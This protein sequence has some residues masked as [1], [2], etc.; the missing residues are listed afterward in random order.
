MYCTSITGTNWPPIIKSYI[1]NMFK[2]DEIVKNQF[3]P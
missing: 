2:T 3:S 1:A